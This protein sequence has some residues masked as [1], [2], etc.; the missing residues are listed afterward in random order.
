MSLQLLSRD[1]KRV[2]DDAFELEQRL[3]ETLEEE[4][5]NQQ[6]AQERLNETLR[7]EA[8]ETREDARRDADQD[9]PALPEN[10]Q[11]VDDE[12]RAWSEDGESVLRAQRE[13]SEEI[14]LQ[15]EFYD[16]T[17]GV[18]DASAGVAAT[19]NECGG[20]GSGDNGDGSDQEVDFVGEHEEDNVWQ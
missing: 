15:R 8:Q 13:D 6:A 18:D 17:G 11:P 10:A 20:G 1:L 14:A 7:Q 3:D 9:L 4:R 5:L 19:P 16:E 12:A 2:K